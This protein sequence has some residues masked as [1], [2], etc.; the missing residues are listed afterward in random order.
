MREKKRGVEAKKEAE[1]G[2]K[3]KERGREEK[4]RGRVGVV[5]LHVMAIELNAS[6]LLCSRSF[7][8][9]VFALIKLKLDVH[10]AAAAAAAD[11]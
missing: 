8:V 4:K 10:A 11:I 6:S 9:T 7:N 1:G 2:E 3:E 5:V